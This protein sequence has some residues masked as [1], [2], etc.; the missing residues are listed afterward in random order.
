VVMRGTG[1]LGEAE[2]SQTYNAAGWE[3][4]PKR[5]PRESEQD[6]AA[7]FLAIHLIAANCRCRHCGPARRCFSPKRT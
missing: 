1:P 6:R 7:A 3:M 4:F 2:R 5:K